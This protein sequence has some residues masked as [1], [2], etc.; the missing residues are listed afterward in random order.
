LDKAIGKP[1]IGAM[2]LLSADIN[3][4]NIKPVHNFQKTNCSDLILQVVPISGEW[5][6]GNAENITEPALKYQMSFGIS[7]TNI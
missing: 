3:A 2:T 4:T 1:S 5:V 7:N 6:L